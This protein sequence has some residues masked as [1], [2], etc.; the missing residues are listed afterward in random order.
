MISGSWSS[1]AKITG[2]ANLVKYWTWPSISNCNSDIMTTLET[3]SLIFTMSG[4][5]T[6]WVN[7]QNCF[8]LGRMISSHLVVQG[9]GLTQFKLR[10]ISSHWS[11]P[12]IDSAQDSLTQWELFTTV[13]NNCVMKRPITHATQILLAHWEFWTRICALICRRLFT[14]KFQ[15]A[16]QAS[17]ST[18]A[19]MSLKIAHGKRSVEGSVTKFPK[20]QFYP[21]N[22]FFNFIV[23]S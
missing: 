9:E 22:S 8:S 19:M 5:M 18:P 23:M 15:S 20:F 10:G 11:F 2:I 14:A 17:S 6:M 21:K 12:V 7:S 1:V 13:L 4:T 3:R 16:M